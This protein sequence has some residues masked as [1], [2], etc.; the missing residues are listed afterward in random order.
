MLDCLD[1]LTI[2]MSTYRCLDQVVAY[3]FPYRLSLSDSAIHSQQGRLSIQFLSEYVCRHF[4]LGR[5]D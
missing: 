1:W 2:F 5:G 3:L 4:S